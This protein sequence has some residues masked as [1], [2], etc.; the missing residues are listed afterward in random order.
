MPT[1]NER[2]ISFRN[3]G[4]VPLTFF[5]TAIPGTQ[6]GTA[7]EIGGGAT[8]TRTVEQMAAGEAALTLQVVVSEGGEEGEYEVQIDM[9][10]EPSSGGGG[11]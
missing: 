5:L 8:V 11:D 7:V 6:Q 2:V 10:T 4:T 1:V 9:D 3:T